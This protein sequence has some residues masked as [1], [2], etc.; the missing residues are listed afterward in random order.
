MNKKLL[1]EFDKSIESYRTMEGYNYD[2]EDRKE[3]SEV[4]ES[5]AEDLREIY[6]LCSDDNFKEAYRNARHLDTLVRD[7]IPQGIWDI[8][9][10]S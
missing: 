8:I 3:M 1:K 9:N 4:H 5:D 10:P 7:L 2:E 6:D